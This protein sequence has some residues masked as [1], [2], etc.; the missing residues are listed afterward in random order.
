[1]I[2]ITRHEGGGF[3]VTVPPESQEDVSIDF[4]DPPTT[5]G[6]AVDMIG[7]E[8]D[9]RITTGNSKQVAISPPPNGTT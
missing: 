4:S 9:V 3:T 7:P 1:M 6:E 8:H 5:A 2:E